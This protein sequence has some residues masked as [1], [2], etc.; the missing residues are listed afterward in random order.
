MNVFDQIIV[1][2]DVIDCNPTF[3]TK[4]D[5]WHIAFGIDSR[6]IIG[7]GVCA[8]SILLNNP[9][10]KINFHVFTDFVE[11]KDLERL[12]KL[13]AYR[14]AKIY[15]YY[16]DKKKFEKF[17]VS[18]GWTYATYYRFAVGGSL[19][20]VAKKVLYLDADILCVDSMKALM[21]SDFKDS[22]IAIVVHDLMDFFRNRIKELAMSSELYFNAGMMYIDVERWNQECISEKAMEKMISGRIFKS[23]DQDVLNLLL[24]QKVQ[25]VDIKWN[26]LYNM[27]TMNHSLP[28]DAA[29]IHFTGD[30]PWYRWTEYHFMS[31]IYH[32]YMQKSPWGDVAL[33]EPA[34]YKQK[35]KMAKSFRKK[36]M[37]IEAA[38]WYYWY[39]VTRFK[40]KSKK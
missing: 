10:E 29:I 31:Y 27:G 40:E 15:I 28:K 39:L 16:I 19:G 33:L 24:D 34:H 32:E 26:Y 5:D 6:F 17:P 12:R 13:S 1:Q 20:E 25:F 4:R 3:D 2:K 21:N 30:K 37:Y 38:K 11:A 7:M 9:D 14:N 23:L 22:N 8:T 18:V 35:R 36:K